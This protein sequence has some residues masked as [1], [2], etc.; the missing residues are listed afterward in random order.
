MPKKTLGNIGARPRQ[1]TFL[2]AWRKHRGLSQGEAGERIGVAHTTVGRK[3][4][5]ANVDQA[6]LEAAAKAYDCEPADFFKRPPWLT[7][8]SHPP[9][10]EE[11]RLLFGHALT[12]L[13]EAMH[14]REQAHPAPGSQPPLKPKV[15]PHGPKSKKK[16]T[17]P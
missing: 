5:G 1:K 6:F 15:P 2:L 3:E 9:D 13:D 7:E 4:R 16:P 17:R 8:A 14:A 12:G 10:L 11:V